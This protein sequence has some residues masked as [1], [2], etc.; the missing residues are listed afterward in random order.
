[1]CCGGDIPQ[2]LLPPPLPYLFLD[3]SS[4]HDLT[5]LLHLN[6]GTNI[7]FTYLMIRVFPVSSDA[8]D[9]I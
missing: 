3:P 6:S 9:F 4:H 2:V 7:D 8:N 1:M 5:Q